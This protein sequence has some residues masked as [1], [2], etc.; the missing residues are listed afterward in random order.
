[1]WMVIFR[2]KSLF[3][4]FKRFGVV[5]ILLAPKKHT[6]QRSNHRRSSPGGQGRAYTPW[7]SNM[8]GTYSHHP[9][10]KEHDLPNLHEDMFHVNLQGCILCACFLDRGVFFLCPVWHRKTPCQSK[11]RRLGSACKAWR[12]SDSMKEYI[13]LYYEFKQ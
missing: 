5:D 3:F 9:F 11:R 8:A 2:E 6:I 1:M 12:R 7:K 4:S 10:R 13:H